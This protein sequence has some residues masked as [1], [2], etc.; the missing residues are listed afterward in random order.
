MLQG[1]AVVDT[2]FVQNTP[3]GV[4]TTIEGVNAN[5][6]ITI[7][8]AGSVAG[9]LGS[10]FMSNNGLGGEND[11]FVDATA[12]AVAHTVTVTDGSIT[13]LAPAAITYDSSDTD[14]VTLST[15]ALIDTFNVTSTNGGNFTPVTTINAGGGNDI[16]NITASGLNSTNN[17]NGQAGDD[18]FNVT[19]F[20]VGAS[21]ILNIDGGGTRR[22]IRS[23][24]MPTAPMSSPRPPPSLTV[25][26]VSSTTPRSRTST[27]PTLIP[28]R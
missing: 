12:D 11:I 19:G 14:D 24:S 28:S 17:F 22:A 13:G 8:N 5:D 25:D 2:F 3:S 18:V 21:V 20:P 27:S 7:T 10:V 26:R 6:Q 9:I 4:A 16:F 15:G 23:M 1:G